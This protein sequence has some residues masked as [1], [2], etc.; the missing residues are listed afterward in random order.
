MRRVATEA[1]EALGFRYPDELEQ[2]VRSYLHRVKDL[3][4]NS[5]MLD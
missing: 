4:R 1:G 2:R 3:G 5:A